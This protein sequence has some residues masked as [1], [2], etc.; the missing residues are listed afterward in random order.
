MALNTVDDLTDPTTNNENLLRLYVWDDII[1]TI[2]SSAR[3]QIT[4][5]DR[6][7]RYGLCLLALLVAIIL[8]WWP[9]LLK[10]AYLTAWKRE[11]IVNHKAK[12]ML[13]SVK[14]AAATA[15]V[16][17][18]AIG[19]T[20]LLRAETAVNGVNAR[21]EQIAQLRQQ[22]R[23]ESSDNVMV[24]IRFGEMVVVGS[25]AVV[26]VMTLAAGLIYF[27]TPNREETEGRLDS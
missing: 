27:S 23:A 10:L 24:M 6:K 26:G 3:T 7:K 2:S 18:S 13:K 15:L 22:A 11:Y 12:I 14:I 9:R 5:I 20:H 4:R 21:S 1:E 17:A 19:Q 8:I 25:V 16:A